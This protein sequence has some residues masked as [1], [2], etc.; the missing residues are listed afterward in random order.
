MDGLQPPQ[1]PG[2]AGSQVQEENNE[3]ND[4]IVIDNDDDQVRHPEA[5]GRGGQLGDPVRQRDVEP[6]E[7][8]QHVLPA[9]DQGAVHH[10]ILELKNK[11]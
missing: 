1:H 11:G 2:L 6:L 8:H 9:E 4:D 5:D 7:Q 10:V 3:D